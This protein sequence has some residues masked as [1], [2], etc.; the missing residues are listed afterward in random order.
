MTLMILVTSLPMNVWATDVVLDEHSHEHEHETVL[1]IESEDLTNITEGID[2]EHTEL[3]EDEEGL[4]K[5]DDDELGVPEDELVVEETTGD[6]VTSSAAIDNTTDTDIDSTTDGA[7]D[8][9]T[10]GAI[11]NTSDSA[12]DIT[13]ESAIDTIEVTTSDAIENSSDSAIEVT[14]GEAIIVTTEGAIDVSTDAAIE[15]VTEEAIEI[16]TESA[17]LI[18]VRDDMDAILEEYGI[19]IGDDEDIIYK[20]VFVDYSA[21]DGTKNPFALV[22]ALEEK[23]KGLTEAEL[24]TFDFYE[25]T[26]TYSVFC[27]VLDA[28]M[29]PVPA[30]TVTVLDDKV[31]IA[32]S[33]NS[34][35][36]S[37]GVVTIKATGSLFSKKTNTV[38]ITN[39][40]DSKAQLSFDYTASTYNSFTIGGV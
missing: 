19:E 8:L 12:I 36:E 24:A 26:E 37:N 21:N 27:A 39:E 31:S 22:T 17:L 11:E 28:A 35:T 18:E 14:T 34:N 3:V 2:I 30:T 20:K 4:D 9:T 38:E 7:I 40:T 25:S 16:I 5:V 32:D 13:T 15:S 6:V 29:N 23:T 10:D 1:P 33:A